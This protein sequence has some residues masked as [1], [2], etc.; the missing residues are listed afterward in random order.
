MTNLASGAISPHMLLAANIAA[1][2]FNFAVSISEYFCFG[3]KITRKV[4]NVCP[5]PNV[6]YALDNQI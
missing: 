4:G 5:Q 2:P 6:F 1:W 3:R